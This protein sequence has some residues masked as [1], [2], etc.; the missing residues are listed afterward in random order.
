MS[1]SATGKYTVSGKIMKNS[2]K[3]IKIQNLSVRLG[4]ERVLDGVSLDANSGEVV[5]ILG[6]NGAGKSS[7]LRAIIGLVKPESGTVLVDGENINSFSDAE[8]A[9]TCSYLPQSQQVHWPLAVEHLVGLGRLPHGG[10]IGSADAV[11][12][13]LELADATEFKGRSVFN[14]SGGERSRVLLARA[15]AVEAPILLADEPVAALDPKHQLQ[16]MEVFKQLAGKGNIIFVVL[17]DL[18]LASRYAD[19][20]CLL[21]DGKLV[22][23]DNVENILASDKLEQTFGVRLKPNEGEV[24]LVPWTQV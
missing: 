12:R 14:L 6:P 17:H 19:K 2:V 18:H 16:V 21:D 11:E 8:R 3:N 22:A 4:G 23:F 20:I 9:K 7:L 13:A 5:A 15:L 24:A 10:D 1:S